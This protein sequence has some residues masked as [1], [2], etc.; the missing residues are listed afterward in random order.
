MST[1]ENEDLKKLVD[2]LLADPQYTGHP[3]RDALQSI[4]NQQEKQRVRM[5]R[6]TRISDGF[7]SMLQEQKEVLKTA[8]THDPLTGIGNRTLLTQRLAEASKQ[9]QETGT[10]YCLAILDTD[11]LKLVND[12]W[13]RATG[14]RI[15]ASVAQ[16][17]AS[18]IREDDVCGRWGGEEFLLIMPGLCLQ[19]CTAVINKVHQAISDLAV[20]VDSA[21]IRI[22]ASIGVTEHKPGENFL[23]T[24]ER[25]DTALIQ[26]KQAGRARCIYRR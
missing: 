23:K 4:R 20:S 9:S 5:D 1:Q 12:T 11:N 8:A 17:L 25:A 3:L 2:Q 13:G 18:S 26:A 16:S 22:T 7:Q 6:V 19:R 10:P 24:L 14:D 15:L 21:L